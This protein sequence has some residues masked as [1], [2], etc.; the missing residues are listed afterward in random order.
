[1]KALARSYCWWKTIDQDIENIVRNC[2]PCCD[3]ANEPP[4]LKH[5]WEYPDTPWERIHVDFAGPFLGHDFLIVV[6]AFTKWV[7]VVIM[8]STSSQ[9]T[10]NQ[11]RTIFARYG[12]PTTLVSD[13]GGQFTSHEF[14]QFM[15]HN[16]I[17]HLRTAPHHPSSNGQAERYVQV[18][19]K[20]LRTM[21]KEP[22]SLNSKLCELLMQY[23]K[24]PHSSTHKSPAELMFGR[25]LKTR[26]DL[27]NRAPKKMRETKTKREFAVGDSVQVR[28]FNSDGKWKFGTVV[29]REGNLMYRVLINGKIERR[30]VDQMRLTQL[31]DDRRPQTSS[32]K[33]LGWPT[34]RDTE[35]RSSQG[36][37]EREDPRPVNDE[38]AASSE[39]Q[40]DLGPNQDGEDS[41]S[42]GQGS[43]RPTQDDGEATSQSGSAMGEPVSPEPAQPRRR[44][45]TSEPSQPEPAQ[46]RRST[47]EPFLPE[48]VQPRRSGR[49]RRQTDRLT[50]Q[51]R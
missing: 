43:S 5:Q 38:D 35:E 3:N 41:S 8:K 16:G 32:G 9:E 14:N 46:P 17:K 24:A 42:Q 11:L 26:L 29:G 45:S 47:S 51:R 20:G 19:K 13:N 10:I 2:R 50:Y 6:D 22:G 27:I 31:M 39:E 33:R 37:E 21:I 15:T 36:R 25:N 4:K 48:P 1:M 28:N 34:Q 23:R 40:E 49:I 18:V 44:S 7:E 12:M 30:H